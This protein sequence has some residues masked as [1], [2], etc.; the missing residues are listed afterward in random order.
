MNMTIILARAFRKIIGTNR[1]NEENFV[2]RLS[3][4]DIDTVLENQNSTS[5]K[6]SNWEGGGQDTKA[7]TRGPTR[8]G[9]TLLL[10]GGQ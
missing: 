4:H 9:N 2:F 5:L 10:G 8:P 1:K 7:N 6:A 3:I